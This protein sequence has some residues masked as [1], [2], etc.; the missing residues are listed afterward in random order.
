MSFFDE[1][2][3]RLKQQLKK[4]NDKEVAEL[5]GLSPVAWTGRKKRGNFPETEL[6]ALTAKRPDLGID[7]GYVLNGVMDS[8]IPAAATEDIA[9]AEQHFIQLVDKRLRELGLSAL[10]ADTKY[11]LGPGPGSI[12]DVLSYKIPSLNRVLLICKKL[13]IPFIGQGLCLSTEETALINNYRNSLPGIKDAVS[14][15]LAETGNVKIYQPKQ[16]ESDN[17]KTT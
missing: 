14:S 15:L 2:T 5:L 10:Q 16:G 6:L 8:T 4:K 7:V 1:A 13:S 11:G 17:E 12:D 3:L 9:D